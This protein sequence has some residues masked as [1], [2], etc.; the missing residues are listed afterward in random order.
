MKS[1]WIPKRLI[2]GVVLLAL[3]WGG[4]T[5]LATAPGE[6]GALA[7]NGT[8]YYVAPTGSD[9]NPGT[10]DYPWQTIQK[11][12]DTLAAGDTVYIKAGIYEEG[13][14]PQNSG[15]AD[16]YIVYAAYPGDTVTLNGAGVTLPEWNG[17]FNL[18]GQDYIR[19]SGLRVINAG[20]G[21]HNPGILVEDASYVLIEHNYVYNSSDSG[22]IVWNSDN[23]IVAHN[24]IEGACYGG[25]NEGISVGR[26]DTFEVKYNHV[27][28][29]IKEGI[30][31]K[32]GASNGKVFGNHVHDT[33]AVGIYVD[34]QTKYTYNIEVF[35]NVVHDIAAN[36]FAVASEQGGS[37]ENVKLYNNVAYH[38]KWVGFDV[39][40]CCIALHPMSNVQI[41][42]NTSYDNGWD[43][44]G[45][46][47]ALDNPQAEGIVIRNNICSQNLYF[48][49]AVE[50]S[51]PAQNVTVDHNLIDGYR[52][53]EGEVYGDDYV[54][55]DP[56][57][58]HAAGGDFHLQP[59]S[60][61]IDKGS[62]TDAP[63]RDF[64]GHAR[65]HG[66]GYDIGADE[67]IVFNNFVY[68]PVILRDYV[69]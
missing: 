61:A 27:H 59:G 47:I 13:V 58:V 53:T 8:V 11:A 31:A 12:A 19:V 49:I 29:S 21:P 2:S 68:L 63:T 40:S 50:P 57:F 65:P 18:V 5:T 43:S 62:S 51:V 14:S 4:Y 60:P 56:M 38:N 7:S 54:T 25:Y 48:Q 44:W 23:V 17:L 28:H 24:E 30:A 69:P 45:G 66:A 26:T 36:G 42:N 64:E 6:R 46:G 10:Q 33:D 39:S 35:E 32:D 37:L 41:I 15:S 52:G 9:S 55:G 20:P 3:L 1:Q 67:Y 22:V 34:A 16:A